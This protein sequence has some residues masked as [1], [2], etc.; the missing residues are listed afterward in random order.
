MGSSLATQWYR[1]G[2]YHM[3]TQEVMVCCGGTTLADFSKWQIPPQRGHG[4]HFCF[5]VVLGF[6]SSYAMV[7]GLSLRDQYG[8]SYM[9]GDHANSIADYWTTAACIPILFPERS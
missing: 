4:F 2:P 5:Q 7:N 3:K 6:L 8:R 1:I 9:A